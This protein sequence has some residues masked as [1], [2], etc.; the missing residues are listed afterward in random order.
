MEQSQNETS[1]IAIQSIEPTAWGCKITAQDKKVYNVSKTK[2]DGTPSV[3]WQQMIDMGL[4]APGLDGSPGS[5]VEIWYR[6]VPNKHGG[7]SRYIASFRETNSKP[8]TSSIEGP[9]RVVRDREG[10]QVA[11][12]EFKPNQR[13]NFASGKKSEVDWDEVSVGKCQ[14]GFLQAYI[15]S[16][17]SIQD[18]KLQVTAARQLAELV[19]YGQQQRQRDLEPTPVEESDSGYNPMVNDEPPIEAYDEPPF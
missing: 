3:A 1:V 19:V 9:H 4:K 5:T 11:P 8:Y 10:S 2:K 18:A 6:E 16:G 13:Q 17:H 7:T 15:Q 12:Q 14:F